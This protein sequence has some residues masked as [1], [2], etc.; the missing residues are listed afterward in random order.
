MVELREATHTRLQL[1]AAELTPVF[2]EVP[3]EI[4]IFDFA[5]SLGLQPRLWIDAVS[6]VAMGRDRRTYRFVKDTRNG[7]IVLA[8]RQAGRNRRPGDALRRRADRR[9]R[10]HAEGDVAP[11]IETAKTPGPEP[12]TRPVATSARE[13]VASR[14]PNIRLSRPANLHPGPRQNFQPPC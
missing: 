7:R 3:A 1:L 10:A 13:P 4:D 6:H 11:A 9:A 2:D 8:D 5:I 12:V 14:L